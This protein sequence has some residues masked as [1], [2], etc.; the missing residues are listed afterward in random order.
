MTRKVNG[1]KL[2]TR[3][4]GTSCPPTKNYQGNVPFIGNPRRY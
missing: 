2:M 4:D 3:V 1:R